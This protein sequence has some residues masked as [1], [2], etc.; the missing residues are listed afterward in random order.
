MRDQLLDLL[1]K[2]YIK[3]DYDNKSILLGLI[4]FYDTLP[5]DISFLTT[6]IIMFHKIREIDLNQEFIFLD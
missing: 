6:K 4:D 2:D 3:N 5:K 1:K